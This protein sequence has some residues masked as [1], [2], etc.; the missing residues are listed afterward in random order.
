MRAALAH[1]FLAFGA[2]KLASQPVLAQEDADP[3]EVV[4]GERLFLET[5]FAQF[6]FA[7]SHGNANATLA[8]GDPVMNHQ[9]TTDAPMPGPFARKSMNCRACHL[10]DEFGATAGAGN[11]TYA[12]FARRSPVPARE[13]GRV[14]TPRNSPSL[15]NATLPKRKT[16]LLHFDGEFDSTVDLVK[17]TFTGRNFGWLPGE[18]KQA[19][20]HIAHIIRGDNGKDSLAQDTGGLSYLVL[21]TGVAPSIPEELVLP[22]KFRVNVYTASDDQIFDAVARLVA[23]YVDSL[24][25][26][27]DDDGAFNS[28]PFDVFLK[29]NNLPRRP[30]K[31]ETN[32]EY[33]RRLRTL[34]EALPNPKFVTPADGRFQFHDQPFVFGTN[35][36]AGLKIFLRE[37]SEL[38]PTAAE[39]SAG[40][41]GNCLACHAP[42]DFTDFRFHNTGVAQAEYDSI[43][44]QGAFSAL[45]IPALKQRAANFDANLPPTARHPNARGPFLSVPSADDP[46]LTDL[47]LWNV[48]ANPDQ[49]KSQAKIRRALVAAFGKLPTDQMLDKAIG[50]FKTPGLRD[51]ADSAPYFHTG[52]FDTLDS[53]VGFYRGI[54]NAT[55]AGA[56]RN[57]DPQLVGVALN[58]EDLDALAAFLKSLTEDYS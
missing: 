55:R 2:F 22:D 30:A 28:S 57:A 20:V 31:R 19:I 39:I 6:F 47:G 12:D 51:L 21:L 35:E 1:L 34:V 48:F 18:Q 8:A 17:G 10:V 26:S 46:A 50:L 36:L 53:V 44:G 54:G 58:S 32:L 52:Q 38:P 24:R 49:K 5:R 42:P 23:A 45:E 29:K 14:T 3:P 40:G 56:V 41:I 9:V 15:V 11:R 16:L 37:P 25:F 43:H 33:A 7:N 4:I 13:D 27:Q